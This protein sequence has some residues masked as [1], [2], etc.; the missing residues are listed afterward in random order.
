MSAF[1]VRA[2]LT[3]FV[4]LD[5]VGLAPVF[6]GLTADRSIAEREGI[7]RR[8]VSVAAFLLLLFGVGGSWLLAQLGISLEAFRVAGGVLLFRIAVD[9][10]FAHLERETPAEA[11][12]A[13]SRSDISVFPLAI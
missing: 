2:F 11:T 3:L 7:A 12:E 9:M 6:L 10:V 13:R 5:P 4:V 1:V 8:A